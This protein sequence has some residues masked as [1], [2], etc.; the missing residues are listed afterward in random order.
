MTTGISGKEYKEQAMPDLREMLG[1]YSTWAQYLRAS[2]R[3]Y[4]TMCLSD[5]CE[6][7]MNGNVSFRNKYAHI[8]TQLHA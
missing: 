5:L 7:S 6:F 8:K 2:Y 3:W 4:R 1:P